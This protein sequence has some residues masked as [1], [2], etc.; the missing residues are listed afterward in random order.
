MVPRAA[1]SIA[2]VDSQETVGEN[3]AATN[4]IDGDPAT[5]WHTQWYAQVALMPHQITIDLGAAHH[6]AGLRYLP[7][8]D[9]GTNGDIAHFQVEVSADGE[10]FE[11]AFEGTFSGS[12]REKEVVFTARSARFVRLQALS[13]VNGNPFAAAAELTVLEQG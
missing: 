4:A 8:Q 9:G 2:S 5:K 12:K 3:G 13:A 11:S 10:H 7:R 1:Y 6:V